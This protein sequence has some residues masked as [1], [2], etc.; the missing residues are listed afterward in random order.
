MA[1]ETFNRQPYN[2]NVP[3]KITNW[4]NEPSLSDL[5]NDA[6]LTKP[7]HDAQMAKI[8]EWNNLRDVEG[9]AR[10]KKVKGRSSVQPKL[11]RRQAEWRYSAL[12]EPFLSSQKLFKVTPVTFEDEDAAKQNELVLNWQFRSKLNKVAF[13]DDLVRSVV[14]DGTAIVRLGWERQTK[15][16]KE[17]A[18]IFEYY[19]VTSQEEMDQFQQAVAARE[20]NIRGFEESAPTE[21]KAA[22]DY[23]LENQVPVSAVQIG[24]QE[25]EVE[26]VIVNQPTAVVQN[27][28][29][30][31]IDPSCGGD[32]NKALFVIVSFETNKAE[33][34]KSNVKYKNLDKIRWEDA[35]PLSQPDHATSTPDSFNFK[36]AARKKVVAYEYWGYYDIHDKGELSPI[37]V[38][39]IGDVIIR[40]EESPFPDKKIPFVVIPYM[41]KKRGLYG[42]T[43]A[44]LLKENQQILGATY[45]GM[46]DLL[47]RSANGQQGIAKGMLDPMNRRRFE[48]GLNYEF[49]P[50]MTPLQGYMEHKYPELPQSGLTM[51]QLQNQEAEALTGVKAFGGG[52]S[53]SAYGDVA[54]GVRGMLDAAAKREMAILRRLAK[55]MQEIGNKIISMNA[56][57]MSDKEVIRVTNK[58]FITVLREDLVGQMDL[59]VDIS[60]TEVDNMK[61]Q[62]LGFMLQTLGPNMDPQIYMMILSEIAELKRMPALAERLKKWEPKPDPMQVEMQ[63]LE[64]AKLKKEIEKLD[65]EIELNVARAGEANAAADGQDIDNQNTANGTKHRQAMESLAEQGQSNQ[66]LEMMKALTKPT[67]EGEKK[68]SV[69]EALGFN[70]LSAIM[71]GKSQVSSPLERDLAAGREPQLNIRSPRFDPVADPALNPAF[72]I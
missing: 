32:F 5:K 59:E 9:S 54:T 7:Q 50:G 23:F 22:V 70:Q 45:R 72:N 36:D 58:E 10:P 31:M 37:V 27:P 18:P 35:T 68:P 26:K 56:E 1:E 17:M 33:L 14:D 60:T 65:S 48:D 4:K 61:A 41:P 24:E 51:M 13:V 2:P 15:M 39:W 62:D 52:L 42:E 30:V 46:V 38:T 71:A 49:N 67:K 3:Q 53:G 63:Q 8:T 44:E 21:V 6:E 25:V 16:V 12:T 34:E 29:N 47:G 55:G 28:Q 19:E 66:R 40:M 43:D 11:I 69:E 20:D 64:M 57:F